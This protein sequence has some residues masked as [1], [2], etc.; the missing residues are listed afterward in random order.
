MERILEIEIVPVVYE[1]EH[2]LEEFQVE[3]VE[4]FEQ[5]GWKVLTIDREEVE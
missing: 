3:L 1:M 2:P 5:Y 4:F